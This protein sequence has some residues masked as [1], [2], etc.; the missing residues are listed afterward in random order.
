MSKRIIISIIIIFTFLNAYCEKKGT[1]EI[2]GTVTNNYS[3]YIYLSYGSHRDSVQVQENRFLFKGSVEFPIEARFHIR[4]GASA[5]DFYLENSDMTVNITIIDNLT[6]INS[7]TGN[8]TALIMAELKK[9][10]LKIQSDPEFTSKLYKK[11]DSL[12]AQNP[13]NQ[14]CGMVL[15]DIAM[16]PILTYEQVSK[17][18]SKLDIRVQN[19]WDMKSLKAS[20][21]KLKN[22]KIG[23]KLGDFEL[24]DS[25]GNLLKFSDYNNNLLLIEF[26]S[27]WCGPCRQSNPELVKIYNR[28]K[29]QGFE[30]FGVSL[31]S[32]K[33]KWMKAVNGDKL[34]WI[35]TIAKGGWDN[36]VVRDLAIQ[37]IPSNFLIDNKGK[38]VAINITPIELE[39]KL[40][41]FLK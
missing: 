7:L 19:K 41:E 3:G 29:N 34:T 38:I 35:N 9:Y 26:W 6:T 39:K 15:S 4:K 20:M 37:S 8:K 2:K 17:L 16:D 25:K 36:H 27:S 18:Y 22:L 10:F 31:D 1:F 23:T 24:P 12:I 28:H 13:R 5:G 11:L 30:I 40:N 21:V 14:F 32:D 33:S